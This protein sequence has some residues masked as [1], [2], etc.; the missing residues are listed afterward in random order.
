M[1]RGG[2][3]SPASRSAVNFGVVG[4]PKPLLLGVAC[5]MVIAGSQMPWL[6]VGWGAS[7]PCPTS[8]SVPQSISPVI[9]PAPASPCPLVCVRYLLSLASRLGN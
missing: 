5:F 2:G 3:F 9:L 4:S 6:W 1:G 7:L 8:F